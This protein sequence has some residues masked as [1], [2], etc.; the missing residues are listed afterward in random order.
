[1]SFGSILKTMFGP[2]GMPREEAKSGL[3]DSMARSF[4]ESTQGGNMDG[5]QLMDMARAYSD[6]LAQQQPQGQARPA[7]AVQTVLGIDPSQLP[8]KAAP[9]ATQ[10]IQP[11]AA[12]NINTTQATG[13]KVGN[14]KQMQMSFSPGVPSMLA[15]LGLVPQRSL[16]AFMVTPASGQKTSNYRP[17]QMMVNAPRAVGPE[18]LAQV[19]AMMRP[20][21]PFGQG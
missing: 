2:D 1:M 16:P 21:G 20:R 17:Q 19:L 11:P 9:D 5:S 7:S 13:S 18:A 6:A 3:N 12:P 8:Q 10:M 4:F 14:Y 15:N